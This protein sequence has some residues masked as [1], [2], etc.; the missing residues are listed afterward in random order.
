MFGYKLGYRLKRLK[1]KWRQWKKS[2][3]KR[4]G[5]EDQTTSPYQ[6]K[7]IRLWKLTLKDTESKLGVSTQGVRQI[8][9]NNLLMIFQYTDGN[10]NSILTIMDVTASGNNVYELNIPPKQSINICDYFDD[11]MDR[12]LN[13]SVTTKRIIIETD[14]DKLVDFQDKELKKQKGDK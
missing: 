6:D 9:K 1:V 14:L 4:I 11:E 13:K 8:E 10:S 3:D 2:M 5:P 7:A 12:R